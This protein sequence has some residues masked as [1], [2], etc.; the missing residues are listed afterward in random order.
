MVTMMKALACL[1]HAKALVLEEL[2]RRRREGTGPGS[3]AQLERF[4]AELDGMSAELQSGAPSGRYVGLGRV[5]VDSWPFDSPLALA[6]LD[7]EQ[8]YKKGVASIVLHW[9]RVAKS[10]ARMAAALSSRSS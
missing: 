1:E 3:I 4:K 10:M 8:V 2:E 7:A 5:I 9:L 6:L